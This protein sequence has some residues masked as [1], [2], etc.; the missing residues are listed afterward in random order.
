M[1][2]RRRFLHSCVKAIRRSWKLPFEST[3]GPNPHF[4]FHAVHRIDGVEEAIFF[5]RILH[6]CQLIENTSQNGCFQW[7]FE[8]IENLASVYWTSDTKCSARFSFTMPSWLQ[9]AKTWVMKWRSPSVMFSQSLK[10]WLRSISSA[11]QEAGLSLFIE[12]PD[13]LMNNGK[14]TNLSFFLWE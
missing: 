13:I 14:S 3:S 10:S 2:L 12:F 11:V 4:F 8:T 7:R 9:K 5:F 6:K 1:S